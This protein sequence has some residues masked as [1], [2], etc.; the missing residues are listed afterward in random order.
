MRLA[1]RH[2]FILVAEVVI[3]S[4]LG[5]TACGGGANDSG[6]SGSN[7][8][9]YKIVLISD[10][11]GAYSS[12]SEPGAAGAEIAVNNINASGGINGKKLDLEVIDSQSSPTVALAG[13]Q[14]A[15]AENPLA[16]IML[17]GS[18]GA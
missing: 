8:S 18:G 17:S 11:S 13:A 4:L 2:R 1:P 16:V 14:K 12:V 9:S 3:L 6:G 5:L 15:M 10:L 7:G